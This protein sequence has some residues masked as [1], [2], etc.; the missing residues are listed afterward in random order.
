MKKKRVLAFLMAASM[1]GGA[2]AGCSSGD[3]PAAQVSG[4][5][6]GDSQN[7]GGLISETPKEFTIFLN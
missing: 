4:Q 2:L 6:E 7:T 5:Q 3:G 1:M